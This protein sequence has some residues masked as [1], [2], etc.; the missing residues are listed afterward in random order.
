MAKRI[1]LISSFPLLVAIAIITIVLAGIGH[2]Q[3]A[4]IPAETSKVDDANA[5]V[6]KLIADYND[7]ARLASALVGTAGQYAWDRK[8]DDA[9][10]LYSAVIDN[11]PDKMFTF[12]DNFISL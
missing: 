3:P 2:G 5:A 12:S 10:R 9:N 7:N 6:D 8:Y 11:H 4:S 1:I